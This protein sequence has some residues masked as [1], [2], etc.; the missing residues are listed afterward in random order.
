MDGD[1][2]FGESRRERPGAI[3]RNHTGGPETSPGKCAKQSQFPAGG[4]EQARAGRTAHVD[5]AGVKRA[6]QTQFQQEFQL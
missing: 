6:K 3:V 2:S 4:Q 1:H 5:V